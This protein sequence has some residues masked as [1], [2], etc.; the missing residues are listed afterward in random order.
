M[1]SKFSVKMASDLS[2]IKAA[3]Q[4]ISQSQS[5][6][7]STV[8]SM[9]KRIGDLEHSGVGVTTHDSHDAEADDAGAASSSAASASRS[10]ETPSLRPADAGTPSPAKSGFTSRIILTTYPN[11]IG[12]KPLPM[13]WGAADPLKRGPVTVSRAPSTIRRRNAIGAHGGSYSVYY[14]LALASK[15]LDP[16]HKP[17]FT[18]TEPAAE[19]GPFPQWG[20]KKKIVSMDPW[21]H[22]VPWTFKDTIKNENGKHS[23]LSRLSRFTAG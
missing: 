18:N 5:Q 16:D 4:A 13:E 21:G 10:A 2:E 19:V 22:L 12:I 6:L 11:Q 1:K 17:D 7:V 14:A 15:E 3:L 20:D 8:N 23:P 9:S